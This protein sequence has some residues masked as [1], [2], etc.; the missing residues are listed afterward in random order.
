MSWVYVDFNTDRL[1]MGVRRDVGDLMTKEELLLYRKQKALNNPNFKLIV[2]TIKEKCVKYP[3]IKVDR[4]FVEDGF[5]N[6]F[7]DLGYR[8]Y[9]GYECLYIFWDDDGD[10]QEAYYLCT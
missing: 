5:C 8:C 3:G 6:I 4:G 7:A 9:A 2:N 1:Q 10:E